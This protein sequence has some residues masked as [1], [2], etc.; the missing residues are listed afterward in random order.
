NSCLQL[1]TKFDVHE[2]AVMRDFSYSVQSDTIREDLLNAI[3]GT[4]AFRHFKECAPAAR[5]RVG[6]VHVPCRGADTD[7]ARLVRRT[8]HRVA[9]ASRSS[10]ASP[11]SLSHCSSWIGTST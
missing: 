11:S 2:W 4:G 3:H 7:C 1:P 5:G 8:S 10:S 6:L 9:I